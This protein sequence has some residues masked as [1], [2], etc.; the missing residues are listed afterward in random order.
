MVVA[1][2]I[3]DDIKDIT[4]INIMKGNDNYGGNEKYV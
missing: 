2:M 4:N 1:N 3:E